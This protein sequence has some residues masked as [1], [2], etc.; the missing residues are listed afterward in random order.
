MLFCLHFPYKLKKL[1]IGNIYKI[2]ILL[3]VK[4]LKWK[5]CNFQAINFKGNTVETKL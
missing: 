2:N 3:T 4:P 5:Y 1:F